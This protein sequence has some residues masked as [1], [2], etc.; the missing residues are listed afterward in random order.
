MES[1]AL[2]AADKPSRYRE[3]LPQLIAD[4]LATLAW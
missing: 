4:L 2:A 3:L 1:I